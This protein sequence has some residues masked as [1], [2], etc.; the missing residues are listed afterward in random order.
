[1]ILFEEELQA[2]ITAL[3]QRMHGRPLVRDEFEDVVRQLENMRLRRAAA[4]AENGVEVV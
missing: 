3:L 1:M 2:E 4:W